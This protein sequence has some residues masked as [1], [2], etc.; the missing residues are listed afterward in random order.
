MPSSPSGNLGVGDMDH[1]F[2]DEEIDLTSRLELS[3]QTRGALVRRSITNPGGQ[4]TLVHTTFFILC[5][6]ASRWFLKSS[7]GISM[8]PAI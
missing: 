4:I 1:V 2:V 6:K 5:L 8:N 3:L 7:T